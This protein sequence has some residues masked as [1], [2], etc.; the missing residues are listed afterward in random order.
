MTNRYLNIIFALTLSIPLLSGQDIHFSQFY[1]APLNTNAA[2]T[3]LIDAKSRLTVNYRNQ[4]SGILQE[5][6]YSTYALSYDHRIP[7]GRKD[8][9][10]FGLNLWHDKAG[11]I[12]F[13]TVAGSLSGAYFKKIGGSFQTD[14]YIGAGF[15]LGI[16]QKGFNQQAARWGNQ[17]NPV[18]RRFDE[19]MNNDE[20]LSAYQ[21][22]YANLGVGAIWWVN[23]DEYNHFFAGGA[24]DH[25]SEPKLSFFEGS[26][27]ELKRKY[28]LHA[29]AALEVNKRLS[30]NPGIIYLFQSP[31]SE[32]N[33]GNSLQFWLDRG[34]RPKSFHL[35]GWVRIASPL[36]EER[37]W[38]ALILS[39]RFDLATFT[40][41]V[42]YDITISSLGSGNRNTGAFELALMYTFSDQH[43]KGVF[44]PTF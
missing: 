37:L 44:C 39:G 34:D 19:Q 30:V 16:A 1:L 25:L 26:D 28:T 41:G 24:I 43:R 18:T 33:L 2:L 27:M 4:W 40:I 5:K 38:D 35:G 14:H 13:G 15:Q 23:V 3:G 32:L 6:A 36:A 11:Q 22:I 17:F 42:S 29:G 10:G 8:Y 7:V 31:H 12:D 20:P 21:I 9:F